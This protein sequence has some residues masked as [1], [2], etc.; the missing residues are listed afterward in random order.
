[1]VLLLVAGVIAQEA[2]AC[3]KFRSC[4]RIFHER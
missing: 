3:Y 4:L 2:A 1:L